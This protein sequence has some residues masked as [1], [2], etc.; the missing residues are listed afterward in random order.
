VLYGGSRVCL[1]DI[2]DGSSQTLMVGERPPSADFVWGWWYAAT[3]QKGEGSGDVVLGVRELNG[4]QW[5]Y[6]PP[7]DLG[8]E[9]FRFG[10]ALSNCHYLHYWSWHPGGANFAFC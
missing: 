2:T 9:H 6:T 7:C 8:P 3:G 1:T 5:F 10:D 4:K